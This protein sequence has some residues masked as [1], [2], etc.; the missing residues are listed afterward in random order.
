LGDFV[1]MANDVP[2]ADVVTLDRVIC[3]YPDV[4]VL[5][6]R[7]AA[8]TRR[9]Y[10]AVYPRRVPWMRAAIGAVNLFQRVRGSAFR[11]FMHDPARIDDRLRAAGLQR[12][13]RQS[14]LGWDVVVY[15]APALGH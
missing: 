14:T 11:V 8:K 13:S 5:V 4:D 12:V 15:A 3:C 9:V 2:D 6:S 10:G 7:S 1:A